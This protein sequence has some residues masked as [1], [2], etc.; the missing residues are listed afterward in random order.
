MWR[1]DRRRTDVIDE[2]ERTDK[3]VPGMW[4][5]ARDRHP[6]DISAA[7]LQ[8]DFDR[9]APIIARAGFST[10]Q[11]RKDCA[12]EEPQVAGVHFDP[13]DAVGSTATAGAVAQRAPAVFIAFGDELGPLVLDAAGN[14]CVEVVH[15]LLLRR[16]W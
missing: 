14:R 16:C 12:A 11:P 13:S 1:L 9:H 7:P 4:Q 10:D 8:K 3:T 2:H 5:H 6:T 15:Y